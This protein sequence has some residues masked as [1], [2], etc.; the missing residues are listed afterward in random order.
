MNNHIL[1]SGKLT[2][3]ENFHYIRNLNISANLRT[4]EYSF[5]KLLSVCDWLGNQIHEFK[6]L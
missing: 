5:I 4:R 2:R 3:N 6:I 1:Y